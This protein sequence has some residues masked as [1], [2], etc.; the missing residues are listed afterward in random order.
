MIQILNILRAGKELIHDTLAVHANSHILLNKRT[1]ADIHLESRLS[2]D[3]IW[4]MVASICAMKTF[5][6]FPTFLSSLSFSFSPFWP[7]TNR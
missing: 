2:S 5:F 4:I 6:Y 3:I 1:S 7:K